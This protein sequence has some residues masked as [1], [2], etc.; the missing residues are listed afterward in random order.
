ML[1][2][3]TQASPRVRVDMLAPVGAI[4]AGAGAE[5]LPG[6][7]TLLGHLLDLLENP[8]YAK[9][10]SR[11]EALLAL[12]ETV[13]VTLQ[14][15]MAPEERRKGAF[16]VGVCALLVVVVCRG[17][18]G[19]FCFG[20]R[21]RSMELTDVGTHNSIKHTTVEERR[22]KRKREEAAA[23]AAK[24][25]E[26]KEKDNKGGKEGEA[27]AAPTAMEGVNTAAAAPASAPA[28]AVAEEDPPLPEPE[29]DSAAALT[30]CVVYDM[31]LAWY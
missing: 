5:E 7:D 26:K 20:L 15:Y 21:G 2:H 18:M 1:L 25:K 10:G 28:E 30:T 29:P 13:A 17:M 23:A 12:V 6:D 3:L 16:I 22:R 8:S 24:E 19:S 31:R 27:A 4:A 11:L 14:G 9:H